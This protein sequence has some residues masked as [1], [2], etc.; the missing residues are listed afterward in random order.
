MTNSNS[1]FIRELYAPFARNTI[2]IDSTRAINCKASKRQG[3]TD[4]IIW[5]LQSVAECWFHMTSFMA[6]NFFSIDLLYHSSTDD[7]LFLKSEK[8]IFLL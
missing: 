7:T 2:E 5:Q 8:E 6:I 3:H 4:L 1:A